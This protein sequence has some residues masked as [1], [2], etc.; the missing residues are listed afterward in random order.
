MSL[1]N[2]L[3]EAAKEGTGIRHIIQR[4]FFYNLFWIDFS[5][6]SHGL[7]QSIP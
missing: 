1:L 4:N 5:L 6:N 7:K 2:C 3:E